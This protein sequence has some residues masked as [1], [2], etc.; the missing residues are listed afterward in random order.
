MEWL[1]AMEKMT[2]D[3]STYQNDRA[4]SSKS[5]ASHQSDMAEVNNRS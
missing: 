5:V 3:D 1:I 4:N 2:H